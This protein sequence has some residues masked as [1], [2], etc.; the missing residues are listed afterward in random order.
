MKW[1]P[2]AFLFFFEE[3][4]Q[5]ELKEDGS[6]FPRRKQKAQKE[7]D[8]K[9]KEHTLVFLQFTSLIYHYAIT[10]PTDLQNQNI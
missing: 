2:F 7:K 3:E 9:K 4:Q 1:S 5:Q 10:A 6:W 8:L